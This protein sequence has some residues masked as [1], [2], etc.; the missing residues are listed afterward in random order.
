[1]VAGAERENAPATEDEPTGLRVPTRD[2]LRAR[3]TC[4]CEATA[5]VRPRVAG[6]HKAVGF[7]CPERREITMAERGAGD[8]VEV[9][10]PAMDVGADEIPR[11]VHRLWSAVVRHDPGARVTWALARLARRR[12]NPNYVVPDAEDERAGKGIPKTLAVA[13]PWESWALRSKVVVGVWGGWGGEAVKPNSFWIVRDRKL[14]YVNLTEAT[15]Y[16]KEL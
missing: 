16:V 3:W 2:E 5:L 6:S 7:M 8:L 1:M 9:L 12:P 15:K 4:D 11:N 13:E 10:V 14:H